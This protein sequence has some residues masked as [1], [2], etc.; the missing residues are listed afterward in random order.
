MC[1]LWLKKSLVRLNIHGGLKDSQGKL[2][3]TRIIKKRPMK[4]IF[5][6]I[7]TLIAVSGIAQ[8]SDQSSGCL[9]SLEIPSSFTPNG[10]GKNDFFT[11]QF[12][13][14]PEDFSI[15]IYNQWGEEIYKSWSH[16][17]SWSGSTDKGDLFPAGVYF[18][19]VNYVALGEKTELS[20][21]L[22]LMR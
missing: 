12:P 10:D 4:N 21:N 18:Y 13:C 19:Q 14:T 5:T 15:R 3:R 17:F 6:L 20:G 22:T 16:L 1:T 2:Y 8:T 7:L 11:I 9:D